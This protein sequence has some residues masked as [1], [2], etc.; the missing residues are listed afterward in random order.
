MLAPCL[1]PPYIHAR[2][3][4]QHSGSARICNF[5]C[6]ARVVPILPDRHTHGHS[7]AMLDS[8]DGSNL[9]N[10]ANLLGFTVI[11][12]RDSATTGGASAVIPGVSVSRKVARGLGSRAT[13][14]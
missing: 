3:Q 1:K 10:Q 11:A 7:G 4:Q 13:D 12:V 9:L 14:Q 8:F 2:K 6:R 5:A